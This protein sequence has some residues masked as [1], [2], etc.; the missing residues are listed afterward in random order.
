MVR[1]ILIL[2]VV[3]SSACARTHLFYD[4]R[5]LRHE[6]IGGKRAVLQQA[7]AEKIKGR[8]VV[9]IDASG[10]EQVITADGPGLKKLGQ[11]ELGALWLATSVG[12]NGGENDLRVRLS[13]NNSV[14]V[15]VHLALDGSVRI[16]SAR[17]PERDDT[18]ALSEEQIRDKFGLAGKLPGKWQEEERRALTQSLESLAPEELDVVRRIT[19]ERENR[20]RDGDLSRAALYEMKGCKAWIFLYS[21]GVKSDR[22]RFVG[23]PSDPRSA[24][25]HSI[26]HEIGH[27]F[28]QS[29]AR[30]QFC[31]AERA[32]GDK[33]NELIGEGNRL[34]ESNPVIEAYRAALAGEPA[35][36]DYGNTSIGES[37]AESFALFHVDPEALKRTR[38]SVHAWFASGG[39]IKAMRPPQG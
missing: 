4:T 3:L 1:V 5:E 21:T 38:P 39:H 26:V 24:V 33:K 15:S 6:P 18:P 17:K 36:T 16:I 2:C 19:F 8:N 35:P 11:A 37:F 31:A 10:N 14:P 29:L 34:T 12:E 7:V 32:R 25:L 13:K 30:K 20:S 23:E 22:F 9:W 27:A 28:E